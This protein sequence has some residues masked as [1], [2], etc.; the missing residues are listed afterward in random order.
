[1]PTL[2]LQDL[3]A[4]DKEAIHDP[5][6][7]QPFGALLA[8][9]M[10]DLR[11]TRASENIEQL[12]GIAASD[13]IGRSL[14]D[15]IGEEPFGRLADALHEGELHSVSPMFMNIAGRKHACHMYYNSTGTTL[16]AEFEMEDEK[17]PV[18]I[19]HPGLLGELPFA[20]IHECRSHE[21]L[22]R[23]LAREVR[24]VTG[25]D[26]VIVY[27]FDEDW[28]GV[29]IAEERNERYNHSFLGHHFPA[30][31]IPV[32]A[33]KLFSLNRLRMIPDVRYTP[34]PLLPHP[35]AAGSARL[36]M[37]YCMLR[38]VAPVHL[39]YL[40]NMD[41]RA[42]L[43]LS[44]MCGDKLWGMVTCHNRSAATVPLHARQHC[45]VLGEVASYAIAGIA[46]NEQVREG[47]MR[48]N[49]LK[50]VQDIF[51]DSTDF[52]EAIRSASP[53][54]L[55]AVDADALVIRLEGQLFEL[56]ATVPP[57]AYE[58]VRQA[59]ERELRGG[60]AYSRNMSS[61]NSG[62]ASAAQIASG[63]LY[64]RLN[65]HGD[66]LL[67]LRAE[68]IEA[69]KW[70]GNPYKPVDLPAG[71]RLHPRKSFELWQESV[72][73]Y[74]RRWNGVDLDAAKELR[75]LL[76]ERS[77][78]IARK[79]FEGAWQQERDRS[80][81]I[82]EAMGEGFL[83]VDRDFAIVRINAE[84]LRL[85]GK[86]ADDVLGRRLWDV[87]PDANDSFS[88]QAYRRAMDERV[89]LSIEKDIG[90][91]RQ[92]PLWVHIRIYPSTDGLALFFSDIS[93]RKNME[94]ALRSMNDTL[95]ERVA[96]RTEELKRTHEQLLQSQK[97]EAL[98]QLTGGIA[99]DFNNLLSS[100]VS[101]HDM[102]RLRLQQGNVHE[103][104]RY[105]GT[106]S[107]AT[108]RAANLTQR[109]LSFARKQD[110]KAAPLDV[111]LLVE[112]VRELIEQ[113]VGSGMRIELATEDD[114]WTTLC[115]AHQLENA[116]LNLAI[117]ARD[118]M[119]QGGTISIITRNVSRNEAA[120]LAPV[121]LAPGDY[122]RISV[123]DT[124]T[125]MPPEVAERAF[126]PFFTT[127]PPGKG[128]G[129]GLSMIYGF[130]KQSGG[131]IGIDTAEGKGTT[132]HLYLPRHS[133]EKAEK[134]EKTDKTQRGHDRQRSQGG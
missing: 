119:Q 71:G 21:E 15:I 82:L 88:G 36:D 11:V 41:V 77:E 101:S 120:G 29:V 68:V 34:V 116:L 90:D 38:N 28:H 50:R 117:N 113:A 109:L 98:G 69:R 133:S 86:N 85:T 45:K 74:S 134:A 70:A 76:L 5:E 56:G 48:K 3:S 6:L 132:V 18:R 130:A 40:S 33:R 83:L 25:F 99:H 79:A 30:S 23:L 92:D 73:G 2:P 10:P 102:L 7:I 49:E 52:P 24:R 103:L 39:E 80:S 112:S 81:D 37:T 94:A 31:D 66:Y 54:I 110:L 55:R 121:R 51:A 87:W 16:I 122:I 47:D 43:T 123:S 115:D 97:M 14:R 95:E 32:P 129:L 65:E 128:T 125:G 105:V 4:C 61:L 67:A 22:A 9:E 19:P 27:R 126:D 96:E 107:R 46:R 64:C 78:Q 111:N 62:L 53:S 106:A 84:G 1:M 114:L 8:L 26:R 91:S 58:L 13:A 127:K 20:A 100:I 118:A 89:S 59:L 44:L 12:L 104:E 35:Q 17:L 60:L 124:G 63:A 42:S 131:A 75:R 93:K 108:E 57:A 72:R